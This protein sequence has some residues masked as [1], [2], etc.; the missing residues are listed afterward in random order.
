[1]VLQWWQL[2]TTVNIYIII[3]L[4]IMANEH[5]YGG[6]RMG[7]SLLHPHL[8]AS[9]I[10]LKTLREHLKF[11]LIFRSTNPRNK[12]RP[13]II[14]EMKCSLGFFSSFST[15][16]SDRLF[17]NYCYFHFGEELFIVRKMHL[18]LEILLISDTA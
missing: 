5:G 1:M 3:L 6:N 17:L 15:L 9:N 14:K 18:F 8:G 12:K 16:H 13:Q 11:P 10:L 4:N 2:T 7:F